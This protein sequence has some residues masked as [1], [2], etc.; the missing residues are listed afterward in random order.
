MLFIVVVVECSQLLLLHEIAFDLLPYAQVAALRDLDRILW[1][2]LVASIVFGRQVLNHVHHV[3]A[4]D[5]MSKHH[6]FAIEVLLRRASD[7]KLRGV[8]VCSRIGHRAQPS[9]VVL[10]LERFVVKVWPID[11]FS[12]NA[13]AFGDVARLNHKVFDDTMKLTAFIAKQLGCIGAA[14]PFVSTTQM[15]EIGGCLRNN[16]VEQLDH[17]SSNRFICNRDIQ[18]YRLSLGFGG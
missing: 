3:H 17:D 7:E 13:I 5:H 2:M 15:I 1:F 12:A 10:E 8:P 4:F 9:F 18:E 14:V 16:V 11:A 6:V